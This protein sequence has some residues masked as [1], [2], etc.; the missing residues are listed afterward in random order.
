[1]L[2]CLAET[3]YCFNVEEVRGGQKLGT[4]LLRRGT[5]FK[6]F[7]EVLEYRIFHC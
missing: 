5:F 4:S 1:M 3:G 2:F 7:S 6:L